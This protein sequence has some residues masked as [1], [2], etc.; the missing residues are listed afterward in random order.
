MLVAM[1]KS[2]SGDT[3][4]RMR[5]FLWAIGNRLPWRAQE[6]EEEEEEAE[7]EEG[8]EEEEEKEE[9]KEEEEESHCILMIL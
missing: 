1:K 6:E 5:M 7:E 8:E 9:E 4:R 3:S 2:S